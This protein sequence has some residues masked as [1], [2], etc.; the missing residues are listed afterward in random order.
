MSAIKTMGIFETQM[1][2]LIQLCITLT[3]KIISTLQ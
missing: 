3:Y 1:L 2:Y